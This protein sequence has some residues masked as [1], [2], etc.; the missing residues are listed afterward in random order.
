MLKW[1]KNG[2]N[3][4]TTQNFKFTFDFDLILLGIN[5]S[6]FFGFFSLSLTEKKLS[7]R[8]GQVGLFFMAGN[9]SMYVARSK[10]SKEEERG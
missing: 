6:I 1:Y 9:R 5:I 7:C 8:Y 4:A 2:H 10:D 3:Q